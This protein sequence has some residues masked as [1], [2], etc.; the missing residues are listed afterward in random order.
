MGDTSGGMLARLKCD[1]I[2]EKPEYVLIIGGGNDFICNVSVSSVQSNIMSI[3][4]QA[5]HTIW[6][7]Y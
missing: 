5:F 6:Y 1:E 7:R 3:A 4:H 2:Y